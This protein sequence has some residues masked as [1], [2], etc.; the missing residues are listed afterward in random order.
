MRLND[1]PARVVAK[2]EIIAVDPLPADLNRIYNWASD[3]EFLEHM[4]S[5]EEIGKK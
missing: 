3:E 2:T 4:N 5:I 1:P